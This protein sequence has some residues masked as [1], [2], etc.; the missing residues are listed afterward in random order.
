MGTE[1]SITELAVSDDEGRYE[2]ANLPAGT[3]TITVSRYGYLALQFGQ[4]RPLEPTQSLEILDCQLADKIDIALP[5]GSVIAG[6]I[7]NQFGE[8]LVAGRVQALRYSYVP[9][10]QRRIIAASSASAPFGF[11]TDDRRSFRRNTRN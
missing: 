4:Q 10:G 3:Y 9:G 2:F 7:M 6:R 1:R 11:A 8:P 5:R